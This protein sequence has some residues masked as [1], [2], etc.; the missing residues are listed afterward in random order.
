MKNTNDFAFYLSQFFS[1]YLP[2]QK[3][4]STNTIASYRD[5][6]KLFLIFCSETKGLKSQ[7]IT[8]NLLTRKIVTEFL[9]WIEKKRKCCLS[10]RNQRLSA[11]HAFFRY[12]QKESPDN[13]FEF[14]KILTI[15]LKRKPKPQVFYLR[16]DELKILFSQP[17][18]SSK[19]GR[20]DLILLVLMY[21]SAA[22]VSEIIDLKVSDIR[23][24]SPAVVALH[25]KGSK[26]RHVPIIGKTKDILAAYLEEHKKYNWGI[27]AQDAPVFFNQQ[28]KKLSRWGVSHILDKYVQMAKNNTKFNTG[29][30]VTPHVLRHSKAMLLL[31]AGINLIYIRDFLGH[32]NVVTTEIYARA[33]TEM[34]RKAIESAYTDLS[35]VDMPNWEEN[36]DLMYWLQNL[37]K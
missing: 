16:S 15:P 34:K 31:Q 18:T 7:N 4:L 2:G 30:A 13:L 28:H 23:L 26:V 33:D 3:N 8:L 24:S 12:V 11:I 27:A 37:C 22:R 36:E 17:D 20:R 25:G 10:T 32:C 5:T 35:P 19:Q 9:E 6:F 21:D 29:F 1:K 14:H